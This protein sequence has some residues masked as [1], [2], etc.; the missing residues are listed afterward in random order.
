MKS[1]TI[2][3][4]RAA[5]PGRRGSR[6]CTGCDVL[7]P[8]RLMAA[9]SLSINDVSRNEGD[10]GAAPLTFTVTRAGDTSG[11]TV[12]AYATSNKT[13]GEGDYQVTSGTVSFAPGQTSKPIDIWIKGD[14]K[15]ESD[16]VFAVNLSA[17]T[18]GATIADA[19]GLGTI[20]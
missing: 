11:S 17:E 6:A 12:V 8:R 7:E 13:A 20:V 18:N 1:R 5:R 4:S 10:S 2:C 14:T 9:A 15:I 3:S 19:Q 16:E